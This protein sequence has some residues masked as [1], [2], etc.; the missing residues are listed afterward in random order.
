[1]RYKETKQRSAEVLRAAFARMGQHDAPF[2]PHVFAVWY[3]VAAGTNI[4][5]SRAVDECLRSEPRLGVET[6]VRL[7]S[8]HIEQM[9]QVALDRAKSLSVNSTLPVRAAADA[10]SE[11]TDGDETS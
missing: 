4:P 9:D 5:L 2:N 6:M 11:R 3:E 7:Y 8:E 10:A 1:M